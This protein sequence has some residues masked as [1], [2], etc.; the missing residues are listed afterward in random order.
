MLNFR[1]PS[2]PWS[3]AIV[4]GL[5]GAFWWSTIAEWNVAHKQLGD[6]IKITGRIKFIAPRRSTG[7]SH[8]YLVVLTI[9]KADRIQSS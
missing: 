2:N 3:Y 8:S 9:Q 6:L 4:I 5:I 1:K 7:K